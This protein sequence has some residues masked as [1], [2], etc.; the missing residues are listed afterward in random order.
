M[1]PEAL[2]TPYDITPLPSLPVVPSL[3]VWAALLLLSILV[4]LLIA[5]VPRRRSR[6][7]DEPAF[8]AALEQLR[9]FEHSTEAEAKRLALSSLAARR[10]LTTLTGVDLSSL[11]AAELLSYADLPKA[12]KKVAESTAALESARFSPTLS[13]PQ[14]TA[15][16]RQLAAELKEAAATYPTTE[17][18]K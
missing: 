18:R 4:T 15:L 17:V 5:G 10:L 16:I 14:V 6:I 7:S 8:A 2:P 9:K 3:L 12:L 11:T 1:T 13:S